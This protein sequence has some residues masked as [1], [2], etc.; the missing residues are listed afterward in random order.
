MTLGQLNLRKNGNYGQGKKK[1]EKKN[2]NLLSY[3]KK[4]EKSSSFRKKIKFMWREPILRF[5]CFVSMIDSNVFIFIF[6][7]DFDFRM[8]HTH[9]RREIEGDK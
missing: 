9:T 3:L 6:L 5:V 4:K 1:K 8:P 7:S 2:R